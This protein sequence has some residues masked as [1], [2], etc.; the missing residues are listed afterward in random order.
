MEQVSTCSIYV[1]GCLYA[2]I[3]LTLLEFKT[4]F[5][6][7]FLPGIQVFNLLVCKFIDSNTHTS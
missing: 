5:L 7:T 2:E 3:K 4:N 1:F 6:C